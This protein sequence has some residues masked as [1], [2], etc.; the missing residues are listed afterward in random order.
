MR[1]IN[2]CIT[3]ECTNNR[4][5]HFIPKCMF[6]TLESAQIS[7]SEQYIGSLQEIIDRN[8]VQLGLETELLRDLHR[9]AAPAPGRGTRPCHG[10]A[11]RVTVIHLESDTGVTVTA[12]RRDFSDLGIHPAQL[13][14]QENLFPSLDS[15]TSST[16]PPR[17]GTRSSLTTTAK[18]LSSYTATPLPAKL[19]AKQWG[20]RNGTPRYS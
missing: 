5:G 4:A 1:Q 13:L 18:R 19:P 15:Q 20:A 11:N 8:P 7:I 10:H 3:G 16:L 9:E 12:D 6:V 2:W 14:N 17:A